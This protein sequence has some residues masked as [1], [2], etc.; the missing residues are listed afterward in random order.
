MLLFSSPSQG[1]GGLRGEQA[2]TAM[3]YRQLRIF[4]F[5]FAESVLSSC[6]SAPLVDW[7]AA[8]Y[9]TIGQIYLQANPLLK[10][11]V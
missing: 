1:R 4:H 5:S 8:N 3:S 2:A 11:L 6:F 9:I 7:N 10:E